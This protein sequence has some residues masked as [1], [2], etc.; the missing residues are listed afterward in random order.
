MSR[1]TGIFEIW[2]DFKE[3]YMSVFNI[4]YKISV[5]P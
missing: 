1:V 4:A 3:I 5:F 2:T